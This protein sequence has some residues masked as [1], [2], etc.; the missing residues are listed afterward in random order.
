MPTRRQ[1]LAAGTVGGAALL[2][3]TAYLARS[4]AYAD[5]VPGG[6]LD[7]RTVPKY[8]TPLF[9]PPTMPGRPGG[10]SGRDMRPEFTKTP[11]PYRGPVPLVVHLH[12]AH[13]TEDSDGYPEAWY[14][15]PARDI[16]GGYARVGTFYE[17]FRAESRVPWPTG[18]A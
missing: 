6:T 17:R 8:V 9:V 3:P 5:P 18:S 14:L 12:G 11:G 13:T 16:P 7:P 2:V 4:P 15:P 10:V 1:V